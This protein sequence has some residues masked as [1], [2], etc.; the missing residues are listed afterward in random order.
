L[1]L[2]PGALDEEMLVL[3]VLDRAGVLAHPGYFFDFDA[4]GPGYH[5]LSLLP[6][7]K[8]FR[9]GAEALCEWLPKLV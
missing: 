2:R 7:P 9:A 4:A 3:N 1:I 5:V 8:E 6:E